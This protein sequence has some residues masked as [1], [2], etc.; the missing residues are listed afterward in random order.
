[1]RAAALAAPFHP[2]V[3]RRMRRRAVGGPG[4]AVGMPVARA[5]RHAPARTDSRR[6]PRSVGRRGARRA[7]PDWH[8]YF[9][10]TRLQAL[11]AQA[12]TNNRDLR[13]AVARVDEARA[14]Y[15]VAARTS[16][17]R[18]APV[19]PTRGFARRAAC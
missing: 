15:G 12:L 14:V 18:S 13:A 9:V 1:M 6:L 11:I 16:G 10:D 2:T 4:T 7:A 3:V 19:R 5:C 17:R 8:A